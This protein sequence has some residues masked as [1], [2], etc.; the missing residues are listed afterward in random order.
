MAVPGVSALEILK[1]LRKAKKVYETFADDYDNAPNRIREVTDTVKFLHDILAELHVELERYRA[2]YPGAESFNRKLQE[3]E[4]FIDKYSELR[5]VSKH[6]KERGDGALKSVK[7]VWQTT[8]FAFDDASQLKSDLNDE[9]VKLNTFMFVF[10]LY[11]H[12][13][14]VTEDSIN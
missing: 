9:M 6:G 7:R 4:R 14:D 13:Y 2:D 5:P 3:C 11:V 12:S 10:A 1:V 8:R